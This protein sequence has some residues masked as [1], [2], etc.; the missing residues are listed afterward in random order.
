MA[1][2]T[3]Y[4]GTNGQTTMAQ[5]LLNNGSDYLSVRVGQDQY[6]FVQGHI[7]P[8][9]NSIAYNGVSW[10]YNSSTQALTYNDSDSG[11]VSIINSSTVY[12]NEP[13]YQSLSVADAFPKMVFLALFALILV[14]VGFN[15]IK[16]RWIV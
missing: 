6:L 9:N 4:N 8:S 7:D 14:I 11:T 10:L 15:L 5:R 13:E 16:K 2:Y 3:Q 12:S 1:S